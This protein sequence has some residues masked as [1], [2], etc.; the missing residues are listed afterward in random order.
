MESVV[1]T[2]LVEPF[3]GRNPKQ[4]PA[5]WI[6]TVALNTWPNVSAHLSFIDCRLVDYAAEWADTHTEIRTLLDKPNAT[7]TDYDAFK[8]SF[9]PTGNRSLSPP[10]LSLIPVLLSKKVS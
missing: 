10:N 7:A 3:T 5:R 9:S 6:K 4:S 1:S 2:S 8:T